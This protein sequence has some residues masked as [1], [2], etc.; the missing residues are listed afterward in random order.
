MSGAAGVARKLQD[1]LG[2]SS[3]PGDQA[4]ARDVGLMR[5]RWW[6]AAMILGQPYTLS[7]CSHVGSLSP[8]CLNKHSI[9][10]LSP[11]PWTDLLHKTSWTSHS[12]FL[13]FFLLLSPAVNR[14]RSTKPGLACRWAAVLKVAVLLRK[15]TICDFGTKARALRIDAVRQSR[16]IRS[17]FSRSREIPDPQKYDL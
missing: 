8:V 3:T 7:P 6:K 11:F 15:R 12:L 14:P 2:A 5:C 1:T 13:S 10:L 4:A 16:C 17:S 9:C